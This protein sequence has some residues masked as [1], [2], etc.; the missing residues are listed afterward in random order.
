LLVGSGAGGQTAS[1]PEPQEEKPFHEYRS[2]SL[3]YVGSMADAPIPEDLTEVA[4]GWFGPAEATHP[5]HGDLWVAASLAVEEANRVDGWNGFPFRLLPSWSENVW[6]T[7]VSQLARMV[8]EEGLW[9]ILGSVDGSATH[10]AEQVVAKALLPLVSP[11]STDESVNLAGVPWMFSVVPGD[12]LWAPVLVEDLLALV[13]EGEFGLVS[14]TDHDS[15]LAADV[16][17][18]ELRRSDR[19]PLQRLDVRPGRTDLASQIE[20]LGFADATALLVIAGPEDGARLLRAIRNQGFDG[21]IFGSPQLARQTCLDLAGE[22]AEGVRLPV[23]RDPKVDGAERRRFES[24]FRL[25]T[26][27][28]A[29][30]AAAHTYDAARLLLAA[31]QKAGLS[32]PGIREALVELAPWQGVTGVVDWDST[33]QNR[34]AVTAMATICEGRLVVDSTGSSTL[35]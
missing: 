31:I 21:P 8:H 23:L 24:D 12:H 34:R 13:G 11:V 35:D 14:V 28:D 16:L 26:G 2:Q 30:W 22:A 33:G 3:E 9:A 15:R 32:R 18:E 7:G 5:L 10:L 6:G 19:G 27:K 29:D 20:R 1:S 25:R 17:L 4:I